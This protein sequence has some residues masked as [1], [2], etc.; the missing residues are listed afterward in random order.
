MKPIIKWTLWQRRWSI[1]WWS[2]AVFGLIFINMIFY[3]S[4]KDQAAELQKSF[5]NIPDSISQFIGGTDFF[6]PIGFLN[7]QIYYLML[8]MILIILAIGLG[9]S[10]LAR[11]EQDKT[12]DALL[13]RSISRTKLMSAKVLSGLV[14]ISLVG[15]VGLLTTIATARIVDLVGVPITHIMLA[16]LVCFLLVLS[17]GAISFTFTALGKARAASIGIGTAI[18]VGS[19]VI[20]SLAG[21]VDWLKL[22]SKLLPFHHYQS[23]AIL[24]G[25]YNWVN[26]L[27]FLLIISVCGLTSWWAFRRRDIS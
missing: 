17:F 13:S 18:A 2:F 23:E 7:S 20:T 12:I 25:N 3:P 6:S 15:L 27:Y 19:Y 26:A 22:P 8:P 5:A 24:R 11:E 10:L 14:V 21:T 9:G 16:T 1:F 4:F